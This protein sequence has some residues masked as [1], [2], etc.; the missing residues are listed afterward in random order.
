MVLRL[1]QD[2]L[3]QTGERSPSTPTSI[4]PPDTGAVLI[5]IARGATM[6]SLVRHRAVDAD[7][8]QCSTMLRE[9]GIRRRLPL[10]I[11]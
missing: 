1:S 2:Q 5:G 11:S 9:F 4:G 6:T 10:A 3:G 8:A 7:A